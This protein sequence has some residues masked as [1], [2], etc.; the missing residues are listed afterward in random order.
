[1]PHVY[2]VFLVNLDQLAVLIV[3]LLPEARRR[4]LSVYFF[5][6]ASLPAQAPLDLVPIAPTAVRELFPLT[7]DALVT[8]T[9]GFIQGHGSL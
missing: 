9:F 6:V 7:K 8:P 2:R 1:M 4:L 5:D 3:D